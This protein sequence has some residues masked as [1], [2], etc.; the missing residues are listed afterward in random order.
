MMKKIKI[1][2]ASHVEIRIHVS[3]EMERD[4]RECARKRCIDC[5]WDQVMIGCKR[6]CLDSDVKDQVLRCTE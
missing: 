2:P 6:M 4:M 5:S 1:F 3:E